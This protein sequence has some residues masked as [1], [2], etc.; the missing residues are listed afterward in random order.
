[1]LA[2]T[3]S[4]SSGETRYGS[5]LPLSS[6]NEQHQRTGRHVLDAYS[7]SNSGW[8]AYKNWSS[9]EW[10]SDEL[11]EVGTWRPVS[12]QPP[13]LFTEHTDKFIVDDDDVDSDTVAESDM[14]LLSRSFLHRVH[15]RVRKI[16][17]Q[18][19]KDAT[20]DSNKHSLIW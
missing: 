9:Q 5:Q 3:A 12:E 16:Q 7:S 17:D 19:S 2:S 18:P 10:K 15:D 6:W 8:N 11:M 20:Q 13:G 1:M 14:S 4:E